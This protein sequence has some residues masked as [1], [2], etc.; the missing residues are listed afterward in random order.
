MV[1]RCA[2]AGWLCWAV[3][4]LFV[5]VAA[6]GVVLASPPQEQQEQ[7]RAFLDAGEF[8]PAVDL[9]RQTT[10]PTQHDAL[11][12]Q[13]A[14]AQAAAGAREASLLS[15]S[16]ISDDRARKKALGGAVRRACR[17]GA[18]SPISIPSSI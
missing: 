4:G 2:C 3:A 13:I 18:Q 6:S 8:A 12:G 10:D 17:R 16:E 7:L 11:L 15:A 14:Q 5:G 9:A 1:A